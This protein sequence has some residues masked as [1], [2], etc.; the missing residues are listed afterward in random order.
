MTRS[1]SHGAPRTLERITTPGPVGDISVLHGGVETGSLPAVFVHGING[2]A[3]QWFGVADAVTERRVI[4]VD[5]RGHG[6]SAPGGGYTA[7]DY[8][9]DVVAA[10][11]I[12]GVARAHLVG[13]SFGAAVCMTLAADEP[14]RVASLSLLG[15]ALSVTATADADAAIAALHR[16]GAEAFFTQAAAAAFGP[17]A[18]AAMLRES[19]RLA[20]GRDLAVIEQV[21]RAAF[22]SDVSA[23]AGR[24]VAPARVMTGDHDLT[25]PP[26]LGAQLATALHTRCSLLPGLGH[27][28]HLEAPRQIA[29]LLVEHLHDVESASRPSFM[30]GS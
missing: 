1:S 23:V 21:L 14:E 19:V 29:E 20:A 17:A 16:D 10:M 12:L 4:A 8:A 7:A 30:R 22:T 15:G 25:C 28:A 9:A 26:E 3:T 6:D 5:L 27:M 13:T 2:A 11:S 18:D 24:V